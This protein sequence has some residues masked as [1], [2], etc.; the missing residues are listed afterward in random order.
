LW[1]EFEPL[2]NIGIFHR[3][4]AGNDRDYEKIAEN[5]RQLVLNYE[6]CRD[7][8]TAESFHIGEMEMRRKK[9]AAN[10]KNLR[11]RRIR[12]W[13]NSYGVYR[14]LSNY[15]T[16][17]LQALT[18]LMALFC[19][20]SLAFLYSGFRTTSEEP[21]RTI[22]YNVLSDPDH[23][24]VTGKEWMRDYFS[25]MCLSAAIVTFQKDR[26]DEPLPG[27]SRAWLF[28]SVIALT[29]QVAMTLLAFRRRFRR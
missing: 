28:L 4:A 23:H 24:R 18:L 10:I 17:W 7:Y 8:D 5:Y 13:L 16:S 14:V 12:K 20:F 22:E 29:G 19:F 27:I 1:D 25:A 15:G 3:N 26:F 21:Q 9:K 11:L 2:Q 6:A